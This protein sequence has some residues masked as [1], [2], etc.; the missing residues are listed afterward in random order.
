MINVLNMSAWLL[1]GALV[2]AI[3]THWRPSEQPVA[4]VQECST[5]CELDI[6]ALG[7]SSEQV[8]A[9]TSACSASGRRLAAI[10]VEAGAVRGRLDAALDAAQI[11]EQLVL[12]LGRELAALRE[13]RLAASLEC[14][15]GVRRVLT[16]EQVRELCARC[17]CLSEE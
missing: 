12:R 16:A 14:V 10:S 11:D 8:S 2:G 1:A 13:Q 7:L 6:R 5:S 15:L 9:V 17:G 4:C 3:I